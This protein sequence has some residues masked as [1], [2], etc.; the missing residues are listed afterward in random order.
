MYG[1]GGERD[2]PESIIEE[3]DGY[4]GARP[5]RIGNAAVHQLQLDVWGDG[6]GLRLPP[7]QVP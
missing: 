2:L 3:L 1:V 5:V 6:A 4:E 7:H